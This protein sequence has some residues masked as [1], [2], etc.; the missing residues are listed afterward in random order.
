MDWAKIFASH[1]TLKGLIL[2]IYKSLLVPQKKKK[3]NTIKIVCRGQSSIA[4]G[5]APLQGKLQDKLILLMDV[6]LKSRNW[7]FMWFTTSTCWHLPKMTQKRNQLK[8]TLRILYSLQHYFKYKESGNNRS[9]QD[10]MTGKIYGIYT[11][12]NSF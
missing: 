10:W 1:S 2:K 6:S 5:K 12:W 9:V 4:L 7:A 11:Q 3:S 8:R